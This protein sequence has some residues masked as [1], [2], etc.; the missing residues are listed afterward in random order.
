VLLTVH[1]LLLWLGF[2]QLLAVWH[3]FLLLLGQSAEGLGCCPRHVPTV[4][5]LQY[6][7]VTGTVAVAGCHEVVQKPR[8]EDCK[9]CTHSA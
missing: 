1:P 5:Q 9:R 4:Q 8:M 6:D 3:D 2:E 7:A